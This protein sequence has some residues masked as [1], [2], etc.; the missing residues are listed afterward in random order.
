MKVTPCWPGLVK[1]GGVGPR[2]PWI[3]DVGSGS[4]FWADHPS[5]FYDF[6]TGTPLAS[7]VGANVVIEWTVTCHG[8]RVTVMRALTL[9][10]LDARRVAKVCRG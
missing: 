5:I 1:V 4:I 9:G 8:A 10:H 2:A 7:N 3:L 6:S